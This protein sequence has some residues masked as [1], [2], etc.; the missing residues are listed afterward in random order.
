MSL[1]VK[2]KNNL[3]TGVKL[4]I[5]LDSSASKLRKFLTIQGYCYDEEGHYKSLSK[6]IK[7][8][9]ESDII[10]EIRC[11]EIPIEY[12]QN[13]WDIVDDELIND[14]RIDNVKGFDSLEKNLQVFLNDLRGLKPEWHCENLL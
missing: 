6:V 14:V 8:G 2:Q 3:M 4:A 5:E 12:F 9:L 1:D 7:N 10:F 13:N 11:Y